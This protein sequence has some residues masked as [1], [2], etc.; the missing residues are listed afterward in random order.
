MRNI[1]K[2]Y[3]I[4]GDALTAWLILKAPF[5]VAFI[6]SFQAIKG[7]HQGIITSVFFFPYVF[8]LFKNLWLEVLHEELLSKL[9]I[10]SGLEIVLHKKLFKITRLTIAALAVA[11]MFLIPPV[12]NSPAS[13]NLS[14]IPVMMI[15][16]VALIFTGALFLL[17]IRFT[18]HI[19]KLMHV[20]ETKRKFDPIKELNKTHRLKILNP[21]A[22]KKSH[23]RIKSI[24]KKV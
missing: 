7:N 5:L 20:L 4:E 11:E 24:L 13:P 12:L 19:G 18:N 16:V 8:L 14:D 23:D 2:K 9:K 22:F 1:I 6:Y 21:V 10:E 3:L 15:V 17:Q